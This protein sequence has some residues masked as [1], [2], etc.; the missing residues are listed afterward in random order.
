MRLTP[1][2]RAFSLR[3]LLAL[4]P[5][6]AVLPMIL[7]A[8][9]LLNW[10]WK[11]GRARGEE[12]MLQL[13]QAQTVTLERELVG[14][15]RELRR[16]GDVLL[17]DKVNPDVF[18]TDALSV[19]NHNL[20][21]DNITLTDAKGRSLI[22]T[23]H[24]T[25]ALGLVDRAQVLLAVQTGFPM[26]SD[27]IASSITGPFQVSI[28]VPILSGDRVIGTVHGELMP[29]ALSEILSPQFNKHVYVTLLDREYRIIGRNQDAERYQGKLIGEQRKA[30]LLKQ[31]GRGSA[32]TESMNGQPHRVS[33]QRLSNGWTVVVGQDIAVFLD[34]RHRALVT[35]LIVGLALLLIGV[36]A[37]QLASRYLVRQFGLLAQNASRFVT[38]ETIDAKSTR[39]TEL[40]ALRRSLGEVADRLLQAQAGRERA[41]SALQEADHR[42]DE[43]LSILAHELRNPMAPMRNALALLQARTRDDPTSQSALTLADRQMGHLIRLVDDLL[44]VARIS[45]GRLD[46]RLESLVIQQVLREAADA[47]QPSLTKRSQQL[48]MQMPVADI[49]MNAD[50]VRLTQVFE[51]LISNASKYSDFGMPIEL[52]LQATAT[53]IE[54][55]IKDRGVG[56]RADE[57]DQVFEIYRQIEGSM[58]HSQGGLG[59]GLALVQRLVM[60]HGGTVTAHSDGPGLGCCFVV[61]LPRSATR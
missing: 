23:H 24:E 39:I 38:G 34:P 50:R 15:R 48:Q 30:V 9:F 16:L 4:L 28:I 21:W 43:F 20:A 53:R 36:L 10:L 61:L 47:L 58:D 42:K 13:L 41:I 57:L 31:P 26:D 22:H 14:Y 44:D 6:A 60:L 35:L 55:R 37:S 46:L 7:F 59:I 49:V 33:W 19:L 54:A 56:L 2:S 29:G 32:E 3:T 51:N 12:D 25:R 27:G 40:D 45:R 17:R 5:L 11:D 18:L 8:F 52:Q 1:S